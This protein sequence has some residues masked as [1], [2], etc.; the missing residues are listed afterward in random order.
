M[1]IIQPTDMTKRIAG[2]AALVLFTLG[3]FVAPLGA[4]AQDA[5]TIG[6]T[7][8]E[9][10][11]ANMPEMEGL[12][13]QLQQE[14]QQEQEEFQNEQEELQQMVEQYQKQ[15]ALLSDEN[16]A[17]REGEIR[18]KQQELQQSA[19]ERDQM[20]AQREQELMQPLM[21]KLQ[22]AIEEVAAERGLAVVMRSQAL[23]YADDAVV[24]ITE[25]VASRLG[26]EIEGTAAATGGNGSSN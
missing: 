10:L 23:L 5:S 4:H 7:N 11:L 24:N 17:E 6:Y 18:Q 21:D 2:L 15:Q 3:A 22:T 14:L 13:T 25:E 20:L 8:Q 9:A 16:K 1:T 26:I 19:R 12:Q